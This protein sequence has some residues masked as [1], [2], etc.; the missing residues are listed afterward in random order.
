MHHI[1]LTHDSGSRVIMP[2]Q[3]VHAIGDNL[4]IA[5]VID[6]VATYAAKHDGYHL[7][8]D[9]CD[10]QPVELI[11]RAYTNTV[12]LISNRASV[13]RSR[14]GAAIIKAYDKTSPNEAATQYAALASLH[15]ELQAL[16][17]D[18][19]IHFTSPEQYA[20]IQP[21]AGRHRTVIMQPMVGIELVQVERM[22]TDTPA[23]YSREL[24]HLAHVVG[25]ELVDALNRQLSPE[26]RPYINDVTGRDNNTL[27]PAAPSHKPS[28]PREA[29]A[30]L[31]EVTIIDQPKS[32]VSISKVRQMR[33]GIQR[34]ERLLNRG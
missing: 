32:A 28:T 12:Q 10:T 23:G 5:D 11:R 14:D 4:A 21:P 29:L 27:I 24:V 22:L 31:A 1:G 6:E 7:V 25:G 15:Q 13:Y 2:A 3:T 19:A 33:D 9:I 20:I 18:D 16:P 26:L 17:E 30:M 8:D 34:I